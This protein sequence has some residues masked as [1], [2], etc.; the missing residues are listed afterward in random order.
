MAKP[1]LSQSDIDSLTSKL[2]A[3]SDSL[4]VAEADKVTADFRSWLKSNFDL[5]AEQITYVDTYPTIVNKFYGNLFSAAF[6]SRGPITFAAPPAN[7]VPRRIKET[8]AN[9]FGEV[10][11]NDQAKG[12]DGSLDVTIDFM[13]L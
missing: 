10:K 5:T 2:Y 4:L 6:L 12:L 7:P 11:Y 8:R 1:I 13:L 9:L 3:Q